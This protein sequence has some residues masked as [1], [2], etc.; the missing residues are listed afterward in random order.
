MIWDELR[1]KFFRN[2]VFKTL[3]NVIDRLCVGLFSLSIDKS[4]VKSNTGWDWI[5]SVF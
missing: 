3:N 2:E 1:E 4:K 5:V